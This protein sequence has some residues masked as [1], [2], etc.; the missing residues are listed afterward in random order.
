MC[1][2][3]YTKLFL[4]SSYKTKPG[5]N[6]AFLLI[7][8]FLASTIRECQVDN[9]AETLNSSHGKNL[10]IRYYSLSCLG[11]ELF[12]YNCIHSFI[13]YSKLMIIWV[14]GVKVK[15]IHDNET[16]THFRFG[17]TLSLWCFI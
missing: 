1:T 13:S 9:W 7:L 6:A 17:G 8:F 2:T 4:Y 15:G 10:C 14:L 16:N 5:E 3:A 12:R 11:S